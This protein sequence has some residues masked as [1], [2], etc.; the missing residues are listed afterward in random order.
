MFGS[1]EKAHRGSVEKDISCV[2]RC[3]GRDRSLSNRIR[4]DLTQAFAMQEEIDEVP[5]KKPVPPDGS[6]SNRPEQILWRL[7]KE[8]E[9][10][11]NLFDF[12]QQLLTT[13]LAPP[14]KPGAGSILC[15]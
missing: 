2:R 14:G 7:V 13:W 10:R 8:G 5:M 9:M 12:A 6:V 3:R 4:S 15:F 1:F 11:K